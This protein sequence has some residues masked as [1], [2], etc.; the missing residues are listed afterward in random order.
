M[1]L[2]WP[3]NNERRAFSG[4]ALH[5]LNIVDIFMKERVVTN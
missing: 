5:G 2:R 3:V 4:T 1:Q